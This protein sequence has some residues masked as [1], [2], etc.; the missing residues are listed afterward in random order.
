MVPTQAP[1]LLDRLLEPHREMMRHPERWPRYPFLAL[2]NPQRRGPDG[3]P[4]LGLLYD[5][6]GASGKDGLQTTVYLVNLLSIGTSITTE[7][8]FLAQPHET[9]GS[10]EEILAA[11]W[12]VD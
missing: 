10:F 9:C 2:I 12:R 8:Q 3:W 11:G 4:Q 6:R 1:T 5:A 7:A